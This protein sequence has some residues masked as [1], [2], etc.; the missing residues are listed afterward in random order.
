VNVI[1]LS[2]AY[3][4]STG[5]TECFSANADWLHSIE[6]C[7]S[8]IRQTSNVEVAY[9]VGCVGLPTSTL[10]PPPGSLLWPSATHSQ[11]QER[12]FPSSVA[13][14][15]LRRLIRNNKSDSNN[16]TYTIVD[17]NP[18]PPPTLNFRLRLSLTQ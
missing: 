18:P 17:E 4:A 7:R 14:C 11:R 13:V 9:G 5:E 15:A 16:H 2:T 8:T 12:Q 1:K 10:G 3:F 6:V